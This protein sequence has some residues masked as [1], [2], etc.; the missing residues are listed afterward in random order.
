MR[1]QKKSKLTV[2][3]FPTYRFKKSNIYSRDDL[4]SGPK[5][6]KLILKTR[7]TE[8]EVQIFMYLY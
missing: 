7:K 5:R 8:I 4:E 6:Q 2:L 1:K 3:N